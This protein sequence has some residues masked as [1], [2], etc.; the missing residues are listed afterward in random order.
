MNRQGILPLPETWRLQIHFSPV[1]KGLLVLLCCS[2]AV[3]QLSYSCHSLASSL[4]RISRFG[5]H[6]RDQIFANCQPTFGEASSSLEGLFLE[7]RVF[8]SK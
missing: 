1:A 8:A 5:P 2:V 4:F 3:I 7:R 6:V